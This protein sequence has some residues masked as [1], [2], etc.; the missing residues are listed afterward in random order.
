LTVCRPGGQIRHKI[1]DVS[2]AVP[3]RAIPGARLLFSLDPA[4]AYLNHGAAGAVPIAVQRAQQ[5]L[6]DEVET[7][8]VRFYS[9]GLTD[10]V[11][12]ARRH[13]AS[14]LG[15]DPEGSALVSNT[16]AAVSIVLHSL[17]LRGG[18]EIVTT[19]H[20]YG[21]VNV[22]VEHACARVG[23]THRVV[24]LALD[25]TDHEVIETMRAAT[26][27]RTR[28]VIIDQVSSPTARLLPVRQVALAVRRVGAAV[29]VDA[30][31][32]PGMLAVQ[33][34][35]LGVDF[36]VGN[37]HKWAY[38]PRGTAVLA[39]AAP[40]RDRIRPLIVSW[41]Q[42]AGFPTSLES[43]GTIDYTPWLAATTGLFTL[44]SLGVETVR[45]HNA[46]L[47]RY[48]Q[49]VVGA[50]LGNALADLPPPSPGVSM[51]VIPLPQRIGDE[52]AAEVAINSR[53]GRGLLRLSAQVYNRADDYERLADGLP[54][55][56]R[57]AHAAVQW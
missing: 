14:F 17:D 20:G 27:A 44:R 26:N 46:A 5:R 2:H 43:Q 21:A 29:L 51:A 32:V 48:A 56:L 45:T 7:N 39:V 10:R 3:P 19:D 49:Q 13:L 9:R 50:S 55:V 57:A 30:A 37:L 34:D 8:P 4:I 36:W 38:A 16:T 52:L 24:S 54:G 35:K 6:R 47:A 1:E 31:H 23:A 11:A 40:W 33:V 42:P 22:A 12:H 28:L 53:H 41:D 18:D 25:P 15:A